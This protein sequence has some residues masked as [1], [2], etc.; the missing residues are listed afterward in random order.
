M[1]WVEK[2]VSVFRYDHIC[3]KPFLFFWIKVGSVWSCPKCMAVYEVIRVS[4]M[5]KDWKRIFT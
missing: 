2:H 4:K 1:P 3:A 5:L